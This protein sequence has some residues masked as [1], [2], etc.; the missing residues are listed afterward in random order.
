MADRK[1]SDSRPSKESTR[2][3]T[4]SLPSLLSDGSNRSQERRLSDTANSIFNYD[5]DV[6]NLAPEPGKPQ[7]RMSFR[8]RLCS[9]LV[10]IFTGVVL[11]I[12][13]AVFALWYIR[14]SEA[15]KNMEGGC[16]SVLTR[17]S[18][19]TSDVIDPLVEMLALKS[20]MN[21]KHSIQDF[22][23]TPRIVVEML[24]YAME[25][26]QGL[27]TTRGLNN[28]AKYLWML[29]RFHSA[30]Q[31]VH[32]DWHTPL[33]ENIYYADHKGMYMA[34]TNLCVL[35][36]YSSRCGL[37]W[38]YGFD[39]RLRDGFNASDFSCSEMCPSLQDLTPGRVDFYKVKDVCGE[40]T[41]LF[42]GRDNYDPLTRPWY[43]RAVNAMGLT[44]WSN[45]YEDQLHED[46][47]H[48][49]LGFTVS[50]AHFKGGKVLM[51]AG[52]TV[53]LDKMTDLLV[54]HNA[55]GAGNHLFIV[56]SNGFMV[57]SSTGR[58]AVICRGH[59]CTHTQMTWNQTHDAEISSAVRYLLAKFGSLASIRRVGVNITKGGRVLSWVP[60]RSG[61]RPFGIS[62]VAVFV[63]PV[64]TYKGNVSADLG[65]KKAEIQELTERLEAK[66]AHDR[67]LT[68][69]GC[70]L[71]MLAGGL[72]LACIAWQVTRPL[73]VIAR[74]MNAVARLELDR[75]DD[76]LQ[77][78]AE[79]GAAG[80]HSM[81]REVAQIRDCFLDMTSGL[82][83]FSRY[84]D[85]YVVQVLLQSQ[86]QAQL[87]V[88][89]ADVT[90]FFS[91]IADFTTITENVPPPVFLDMLG[92]YLDRMSGIIMKHHGVV[93]EFIGDGIMA[94][95]NV[96]VDLGDRHTR[97][98]LAAALEQQRVLSELRPIWCQ[99]GLPEVHARMGLVRG[100]EV[101]AGN[102]GSRNRMKFGLVGDKV[103]LASRLE[104]LCKRYCVHV[105]VDGEAYEAPGVKDDYFLRPIDVVVVKG[106]SETTD[107]YELVAHRD[108]VMGTSLQAMYERFCEDFAE[109]HA[110]YREREFQKALDLLVP[111]LQ[112]WPSDKPAR[113]MKERCEALLESPPGEE[114]SHAERL[115][116]K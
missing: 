46:G 27:V 55:D 88:A 50:R 52:S 2:I 79:G 1:R 29:Q 38:Q 61:S 91:D 49:D 36:G 54:H 28:N 24:E 51:V 90:I 5:Q 60:L 110:L 16:H 64:Q 87:G 115:S 66:M 108:S 59:G 44:A 101:Y 104:S 40:P 6:N 99:R 76:V 43:K 73:K 56:D 21:L 31:R 113:I 100:K 41:A 4:M 63:Q 45:I 98:G 19:V 33:L 35:P 82:R 26:T 65:A 103:N 84:M 71:I 12:L 58:S 39:L 109:V 7:C 70:V 53:T 114:W 3:T 69:C 83:S 81:I 37:N 116:E 9:V 14:E 13:G 95:W 25:D 11:L 62:W 111:Y 106:R 23:D 67:I 22:L 107:L 105:L 20:A 85:P 96:P 68:I 32:G 74:D 102:I 34:Y 93:G 80:S 42:G 48:P 94:W 15:R 75:V 77:G 112:L 8:P 57:A 18:D 78:R 17:F 97:A 89:R 92:E 47:S 30:S 86:R 10:G 72:S